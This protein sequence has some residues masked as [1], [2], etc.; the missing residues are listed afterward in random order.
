MDYSEV[1][2][3]DLNDDVVGSMEK[4]EAHRQG[5]LHRAFSVF[6]FKSSGEMLLQQRALDKYHSPGLWT[7]ACCSHPA[8]GEDTIGA[9]KRRLVEELGFLCDLVE[10][11]SFVYR[12]NF[13]NG[14]T[15]HEFDHVYVGY[16]DGEIDLNRQEV[17]AVKWITIKAL[18]ADLVKRKDDY[19]YWFQIAYP[20]VKEWLQATR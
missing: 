14:L 20:L 1:V 18:D 16:F 13:D 3:V 19:T 12:A 5:L 4:L 10:I 9:A 6:I 11:G 17:E 15:E 2:L 7:N 8:M